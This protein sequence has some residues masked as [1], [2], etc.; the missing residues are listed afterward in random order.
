[1]RVKLFDEIDISDLD[2]RPVDPSELTR[3]VHFKTSVRVWFQRGA[4][5]RIFSSSGKDKAIKERLALISEVKTVILNNIYTSMKDTN[6]CRV[7]VPREYESILN[8]VLNSS[9]FIPY[10]K[11]RIYENNDVLLSFPDLPILIEFK[12]V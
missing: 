2:N 11:R 10:E 9:E 4:L 6:I 7:R 8:D 3:W 12:V 1:M 5:Y